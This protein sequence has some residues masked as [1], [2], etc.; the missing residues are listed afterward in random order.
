[1]MRSVMYVRSSSYPSS[2]L[3]CGAPLSQKERDRRVRGFRAASH[4]R[5]V[6][7]GYIPGYTLKG[8]REGAIEL[9]GM[10]GAMCLE[11][12]SL[13]ER[14]LAVFEVW[15]PCGTVLLLTDSC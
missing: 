10:K 8:A 12:S 5:H 3:E 9:S 6:T 4:H 1:M 13:E 15:W 7:T 11:R 14:E 2:M